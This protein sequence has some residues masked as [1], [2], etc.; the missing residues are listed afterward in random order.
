MSAAEPPINAHFPE[1]ITPQQL[2]AYYTP[3]P[4][5]LEWARRST[6][7]ERPRLGLLVLLKVFQ[8]AHY[9]PP[10]EDIPEIL[11]EHVRAV[12]QIGADAQFGYDMRSQATLFRHY[13]T[14]RDYLRLR[15]Y[16]GAIETFG[17]YEF[18]PGAKQVLVR[19]EPVSLT[20]KEFELARLLFRHATQPLARSYLLRAIWQTREV[21]SRTLDTHISL[22]RVKLGLYPENGYRL[23]SV[24]AY[25]YCLDRVEPLNRRM[26]TA[27]RHARR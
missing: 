5:E 21:S 11:V 4:T 12:A 25:G 10:L 9:F 13:T 3:L 1:T 23:I 15:H 7:G 27:S 22:L 6:R 8:Q 26:W 20:S 14:V 17:D 19:G 24:Y 18:D 16:T 2:H